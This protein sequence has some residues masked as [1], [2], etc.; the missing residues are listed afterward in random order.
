MQG[1]CTKIWTKTT[2]AH[3]KKC[4]RIE[5]SVAEGKWVGQKREL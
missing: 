1:Y 3:V 2:S 4:S 5:I